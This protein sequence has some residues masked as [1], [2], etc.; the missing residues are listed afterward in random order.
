MGIDWDRLVLS[1]VMG[2]FEEDVLYMPAAGLPYAAT[3]VFTEGFESIDLG[4]DEPPATSELPRI[5]VRLSQLSTAPGQGDQL[6]IRSLT[7]V[8]QEVRLDSHG[9]ADLILNYVSG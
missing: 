3:G 2:T 1:P 4:P 8:V 6:V 5:G 9:R 7:Y